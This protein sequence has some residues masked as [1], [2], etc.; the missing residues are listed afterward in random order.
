V[1]G[2]LDGRFP[3]RLFRGAAGLVVILFGALYIATV[4]HWLFI[5]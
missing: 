2:R 3:P 1:A 4:I 5:R